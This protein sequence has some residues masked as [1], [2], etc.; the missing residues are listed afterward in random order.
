MKIGIIGA[1]DVEVN[2]IKEKI[3]NS[4]PEEYQFCNL[5]EEKAMELGFY[6]NNKIKDFNAYYIPLWYWKN[7]PVGTQLYCCVLAD[8][9][10]SVYVKKENGETLPEDRGGYVISC[11]KF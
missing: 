7:I 10:V 8:K 9:E 3:E 1:M 6:Y 5:T 11:V 2:G 4:I